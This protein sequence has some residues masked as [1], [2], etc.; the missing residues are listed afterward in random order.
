MSQL[1]I[2]VR[3][4]V[5]EA[6]VYED[7]FAA[8]WEGHIGAAR[9][10]VPMEAVAIAHRVHPATHGQLGLRVLAADSA[11]GRAAYFRAYS[12]QNPLPPDLFQPTVTL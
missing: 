4:L 11:H 10:V 5:P 9:K 3:V 7:D 8:A 2:R 1:A 6:S 12:I